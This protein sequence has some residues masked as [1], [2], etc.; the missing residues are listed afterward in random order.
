LIKGVGKKRDGG[1]I[2]WF[3]SCLSEVV[4]DACMR[5]WGVG[6]RWLQEW[7]MCGESH[8]SER[9]IT[10]ERKNGREFGILGLINHKS[11]F[12]LYLCSLDLMG[13]TNFYT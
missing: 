11:R 8:E 9:E 6:L 12:K 3:P 4:L 10:R 2:F 1:V 5:W 7:V 13:L